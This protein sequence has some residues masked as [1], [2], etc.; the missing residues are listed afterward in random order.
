MTR[1]SADGWHFEHPRTELDLALGD[2]QV[3]LVFITSPANSPL[4]RQFGR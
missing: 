3:D 1:E 4:A 2:P